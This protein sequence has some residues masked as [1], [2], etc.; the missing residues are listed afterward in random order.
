MK[1][2]RIKVSVRNNLMLSAIEAA[3]YKSVADFERAAELRCGA[4]NSLVAMRDCPIN[5]SGEFSLIAKAIM[6]VLGAAPTDLWTP[7]Q[8]V[9]KL[10]RNVGWKEVDMDVGQF[11]ALLQHHQQEAAYLPAPDDEVMQIE[12]ARLIDDLL[13]NKVPDRERLAIRGIMNDETLETIGKRLNVTKERIR[14]ILIK[15]LRRLRHPKNTEIF[16][17]AGLNE[18][19]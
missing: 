5:A 13:A 15:G 14:Q 7:D 16:K 8:L 4:V 1:A 9:M 19:V 3:G 6:E 18:Q 10:K 11:R 2:F 12:T 17:K